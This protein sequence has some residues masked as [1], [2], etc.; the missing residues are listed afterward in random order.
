MVTYSRV[1][2]ELI[3]SVAKLMHKPNVD[4]TKE[5]QSLLV[6]KVNG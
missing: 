1:L 4:L 3:T 6:I 5:A 2:F